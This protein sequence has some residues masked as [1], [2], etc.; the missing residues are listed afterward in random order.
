[1]VS[2]FLKVLEK[3]YGKGEI[4]NNLTIS[5]GEFLYFFLILFVLTIG[6]PDIIDSVIKVLDAFATYLTR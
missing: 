5:F 2:D 3:I 4:M 1:M 6:E